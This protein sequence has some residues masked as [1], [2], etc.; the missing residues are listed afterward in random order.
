MATA[1]IMP[2]KQRAEQIRGGSDP[3]EAKIS[4]EDCIR[5]ITDLEL[6][7]QKLEGM[8]GLGDEIAKSRRLKRRANKLLELEEE[9]LYRN[10]FEIQVQ[11]EDAPPAK[12]EDL[13]TQLR[14]EKRNLEIF[15]DKHGM[16]V[17][18]SG[19]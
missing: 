6:D 18:G 4:L 9:Q 15:Y 11:L 7:I 13:E 17:S 8:E 1:K 2:A 12:K 19:S 10:I 5:N 3:K 14:E 16:G